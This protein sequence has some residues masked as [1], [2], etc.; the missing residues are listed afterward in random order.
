MHRIRAQR[1]F[2]VF[3][4]LFLAAGASSPILLGQ[5][6]DEEVATQESIFNLPLGYIVTPS[7][8]DLFNETARMVDFAWLE[9]DRLSLAFELLRGRIVFE[10]ESSLDPLNLPSPLKA[11]CEYF[12]LGQDAQLSDAVNLRAMANFFNKKTALAPDGDRALADNASL[13]AA[14]APYADLFLIRADTWLEEDRSPALDDFLANVHSV[15]EAARRANP[16]IKLQ[17]WLGRD[18]G[19]NPLAV[20]ILFKALSLLAERFPRDL[21]SFGLGRKDVWT[22]PQYGNNLLAQTQFFIRRLESVRALAPA[23]PADFLAAVAGYSEVFLTWTDASLDESGF[24]LKRG[25]TAGRP[26]SALAEIPPRSGT[27]SLLDAVPSPGTYYYRVCAFNSQG[28]SKFSELRAVD[29]LG[30]QVNLPPRFEPPPVVTASKGVPLDLRLSASDPEGDPLTYTL[31]LHPAGMVIDSGSGT[32]SWLPS[33][34]GRFAVSATV[35]DGRA[36]DFLWF[37]IDVRNNI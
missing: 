17:I 1:L 7:V 37:E 27:V 18:D 16:K 4:A 36:A 25:A 12:A 20:E 6:F 2:S 21:E 29:T 5:V 11:L 9:P 33:A 15:A 28:L 3:W 34:S 8:L 24:L 14:M 22:E 31:S 26:P 19:T 32:I 35:S 10:F 13:T 30:G 23:P